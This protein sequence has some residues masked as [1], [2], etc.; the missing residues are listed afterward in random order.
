MAALLFIGFGVKAGVIGVHVWLP[1]AHPVA[2][3]PASAVLSGVMIKAGL[4]GWIS[5]LPLG[6]E[7]ISDTLVQFGNFMLVAGLVAALPQRCMAFFSAIP[8][9]F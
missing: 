4:L 6:H 7:D 3:A 9:L 1:L 2:P 5:V 8:K